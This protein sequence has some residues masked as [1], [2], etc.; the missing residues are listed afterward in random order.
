MDFLCYKYKPTNFKDIEYNL[1]VKKKL[2][3]FSEDK[4]ILNMI[5]Y[6]PSGSGK[7][8]LLM[9]YLNNYFDNDNSIYI[10]NTFDFVLSNNYK[11]FYKVTI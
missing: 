9:C 2:M 11:V 4:T 5:L 8:T 7:K 3:I 1:D 6:G 10:L